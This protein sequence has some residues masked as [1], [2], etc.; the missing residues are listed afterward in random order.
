[1]LATMVYMLQF[2]PRNFS[3]DIILAREE[4]VDRLFAHPHT[5]GELFHGCFAEAVLKK[6]LPGGFENSGF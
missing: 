1:M 3:D 6:I 5:L 4:F 2:F